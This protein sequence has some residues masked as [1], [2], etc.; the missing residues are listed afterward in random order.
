MQKNIIW[1]GLDADTEENC[2]ISYIGDGITVRSEISGWANRQPVSAEYVIKLDNE[3][4]VLEF[5][6]TVQ[7]GNSP[8]R[9]YAMR[10]D[11]SG[12]WKGFSGIDYPEYFGCKYIDISLTPFTNTLPVNG[13]HLKEGETRDV[14]V[15]YMD[16]LENELRRERQHY[17]RMGRLKYRFAN[18]NNF[19]AD[20]DV[21]EDGFVTNY[22]ELFELI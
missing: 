6:V 13:L 22:P 7:I 15:V 1:K 12:N 4:T 20:I 17:T 16:V 10:R 19:T 3:W 9:C 14:D 18:D 21:D 8:A 5:Q 2:A 11:A